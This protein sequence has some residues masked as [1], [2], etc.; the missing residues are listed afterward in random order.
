[1]HIDYLQEY[2]KNPGSGLRV[3]LGYRRISNMLFQAYLQ[4]VLQ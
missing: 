2:R 3:D 1:M 4:L